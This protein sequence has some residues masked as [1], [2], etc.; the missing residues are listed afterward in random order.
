MG[1]GVGV[2]V[3]VG[4]EMVEYDILK[5][6][7]CTLSS[8]VNLRY[9]ELPVEIMSWGRSVPQYVANNGEFSLFPSQIW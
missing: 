7:P 5:P 9:I 2:G 8:V 6:L 1:V 3:G 4:A